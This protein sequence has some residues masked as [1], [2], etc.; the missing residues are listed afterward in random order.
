M[1]PASLRS[2]PSFELAQKPPIPRRT[3][4]LG[5]RIDLAHNVHTTLPNYNHQPSITIRNRAAAACRSFD[6]PHDPHY[7]VCLFLSNA[8]TEVRDLHDTETKRPRK[9]RC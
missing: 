9:P 1:R 3:L 5:H 8:K 4:P 7:D 6:G 2:C